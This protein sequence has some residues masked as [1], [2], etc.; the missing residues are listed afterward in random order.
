MGRSQ[1][2]FAYSEQE[3]IAAQADKVMHEVSSISRRLVIVFGNEKD[4]SSEMITDVAT[5]Q[6]RIPTDSKVESLKVSTAAGN[7]LYHRLWFN[8]SQVKK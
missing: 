4:G 6:V 3:V 7:M 1:K 8:H 5:L 2:L